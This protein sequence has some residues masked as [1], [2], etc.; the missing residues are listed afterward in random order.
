MIRLIRIEFMKLK[1]TRY[2]WVF[3]ILF[4]L[5]LLAV[6]LFSKS[7]LDYFTAQGAEIYGIG[8]NDLPFFDF[9]DIWQNLTYLFK[10]PAILLAF[11]P[12]ISMANEFRYGTV[13]QNVIDG[14]S[15][16]ELISSKILFAAALSL[17]MGVIVLLIGLIMGYSWSQ[18]TEFSY[19]IKHVEF[20]LAFVMV[21][22]SYQLFCLLVTL[23]VK[24]SGITILLLLFYFFA[25]EG[26]AYGVMAWDYKVPFM[27][28][29]LPLRGAG[30]IISNPFPKYA[31]Q[32]VLTSVAWVNVCITLGHIALYSSLSIWLFN[33]RDVR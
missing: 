32:Q 10:W 29:F 15:R 8:L 6:P 4:S 24:R 30:N 11:I 28:N 31:L 20:V 33:R 3:T 17:V 23:L 22:F 7:F 9:L 2:F 21:L 13:K 27:T 14:L 5:F 26:I 16:T 12:V 18:V 25:L 19:V 1:N